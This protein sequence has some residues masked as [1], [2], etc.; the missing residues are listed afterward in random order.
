MWGMSCENRQPTPLERAQQVCMLRLT[1]PHNPK[2]PAARWAA[3]RPDRGGSRD[4]RF[5]SCPR[6]QKSLLSR[7]GWQGFSVMEHDVSPRPFRL[8]ARAHNPKGPA[9]RWAASRPVPV[10]PSFCGFSASSTPQKI[11]PELLGS[12]VVFPFSFCASLGLFQTPGRTESPLDRECR[13]AQPPVIRRCQR[14]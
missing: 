7:L 8:G 12:G 14:P 2:G 13:S 11:T 6:N 4:R 3:S 9:A 5:K 10:W 1:T